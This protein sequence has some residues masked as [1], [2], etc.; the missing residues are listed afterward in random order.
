M[1]DQDVGIHAGWPGNKFSLPIATMNVLE[2]IVSW[3]PIEYN[4]L[5]P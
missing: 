5:Q 3:L 4:Q 2:Y 1:I